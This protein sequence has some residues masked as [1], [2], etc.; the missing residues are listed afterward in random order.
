MGAAG[1]LATTR[2]R[3]GADCAY[4]AVVCGERTLV[5][6]VS[7]EKGVY[8]RQYQDAV[9]SFVVVRALV[10]ACGLA[11]S[12]EVLLP[13]TLR[14]VTSE[15]KVVEEGTSKDPVD[16]LLSGNANTLAYL[17]NGKPAIADIPWDATGTTPV[18]LS[19][20]FNP[21]HDGH[22]NL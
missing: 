12:D 1:G 13:T 6:S 7:F 16:A 4:V 22:E 5:H 11:S 14:G 2:E 19:G 18:I 3:R 17:G 8:N 10:E 15:I 21:V 9:V 20:S